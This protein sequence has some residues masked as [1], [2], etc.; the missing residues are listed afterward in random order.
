MTQ[1]SLPARS[2]I[3]TAQTWNLNP[4]FENIEAWEKTFELLPKPEQVATELQNLF[5]G[6]LSQ[7]PETIYAALKYRDTLNRRLENLNI[8][9]F[10]NNAQD[11]SDSKSN[12]MMGRMG[13]V[14]SNLMAN[15][16]FLEPELLAIAS[17]SKWVSEKPLSEYSVELT[18]LLRTKKHILS[19]AE[20]SL[21]MQL[22]MPLSSFSGI[23]SQWNNVDL[24]FPAALDAQNKEHLVS[25]GRLN[26]LLTSTDRVLRKNSFESF[27]TEVAK[28]RNTIASNFNAHLLTGS[29][30]ARVRKFES[31]IDASMH[32]DEI[33]LNVYD[34]LV[35]EV[36]NQLPLF[37]RSIALRCKVLKLD[38]LSAFDRIVSLTGEAGPKFSWEEGCHLILESLAPLGE[39]YVS[40]AKKGLL[41]DRWA[42]YSEN[43]GKRS[44]AFSW[45]SY[46][47][48]PYML[49][50]WTGTLNDVF[51]LAHELGHSMHTY[52]SNKN[53]P[54]ETSQYTI[55]VA[56]VASTLNEALLRDFI[57]NSPNHKNLARHVVG[58]TLLGFEGTVVRQVMFAAFERQASR[59]ADEGQTLTA[60]ALDGIYEKLSEQWFGAQCEMHAL[61]KHEWMRIPHFYNTF[62]VYKYATSY[63]ASA[64]LA[65]NLKKDPKAT[66]ARIFSLLKAG[67]SQSPLSILKNA[68]VDFLSPTPVQNAFA[69]YEQ[70]IAVA[71]KLFS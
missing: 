52:Y 57:L 32:S 49:M 36:Q 61:Q 58:E 62:Y 26:S 12:D 1:N 13:I 43:A 10:F 11:V 8:Y 54:Y 9:A 51:T 67:K 18:D 37:H 35:A 53:Q 40:I 19:S 55:F 6:K 48:L 22:S 7:N 42:D 38:K 45:G 29:T 17:L 69:L 24:K 28:W 5:V 71:E 65:L 14:S 56:E 20:E 59:A 4:L 34:G 63:C 46:E 50:T 15:F 44:G 16:A 41:T 23:H 39:E 70:N 64:D 31:F 25:H 21:L 27:N 47:S 2:T 30:L 3:S 68:G 66:Q 60:D 33:P